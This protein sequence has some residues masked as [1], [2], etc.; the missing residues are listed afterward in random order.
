MFLQGWR[1]TLR[2]FPAVPQHWPTAAF[3]DLLAEGAFRVSAVRREG[4][5]TWVRIVAGVDR[6][7]RLRNPFGQEPV[8][9]S[10]AVLRREGHELVADLTKGQAVL[11]RLKGEPAGFEE[12]AR[13]ARQGNISR[14]GLR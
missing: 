14:I 6:R 4:R 9:I 12:A 10:G 3:R 11:L 2:I 5:T 8:E 13:G 1:D 7:L